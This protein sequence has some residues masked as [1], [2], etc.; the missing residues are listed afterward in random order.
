MTYFISS[1]FVHILYWGVL[2]LLCVAAGIH[3]RRKGR[4]AEELK[5][6]CTEQVTAVCIDKQGKGLTRSRSYNCTY[7]FVYNGYTYT[8]NNGIWHGYGGF[9]GL[10]EG[11]EVSIYIDPYDPE[12]NIFDPIASSA[13]FTGR[14]LSAFFILLGVFTF[15]MPILDTLGVI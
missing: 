1:D 15:V 7:R 5:R 3:L 8:A 2:F 6:R 9:L 4:L 13:V 10:K 11:S 14:Y 12:R